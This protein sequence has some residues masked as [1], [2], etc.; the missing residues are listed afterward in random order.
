MGHLSLA[1]LITA[2]S[3]TR[4]YHPNVPEVFAPDK[5]GAYRSQPALWEFERKE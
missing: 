5:S 1:S 4:S 2:W 3:R